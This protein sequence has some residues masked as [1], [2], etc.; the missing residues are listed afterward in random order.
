MRYLPVLLTTVTFLNEFDLA[1]DFPSTA[2]LSKYTKRIIKNSAALREV[3]WCGKI[4]VED[5]DFF[6][7]DLFV[8]FS[9]SLRFLKYSLSFVDG[10][11]SRVLF[12]F[13]SVS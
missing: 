5:K 6:M 1:V 4:R 9:R 2:M 8:I 13:W 7:I 10:F 12:L 11:K 3:K